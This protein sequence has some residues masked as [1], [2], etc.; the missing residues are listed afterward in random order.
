LFTTGEKPTLVSTAS[1]QADA[2]IPDGVNLYFPEF[3]EWHEGRDKTALHLAAPVM[4]GD[5]VY[6]RSKTHLYCFGK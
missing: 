2:C 5:K 3:T 1:I 4:Y 6:Y